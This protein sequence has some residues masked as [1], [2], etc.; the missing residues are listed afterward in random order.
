MEIVE[1][2]GWDVKTQVVTGNS[3]LGFFEGVTMS[4]LDNLQIL[5]MCI[6]GMRIRMKMLQLGLL[7]KDLHSILILR[8]GRKTDILVRGISEIY[9]R[10]NFLFL[11]FY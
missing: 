1:M 4:L 2:L 7:S 8:N 9:W 6:S 5:R 3:R 10:N 11:I